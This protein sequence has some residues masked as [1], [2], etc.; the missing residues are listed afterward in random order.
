MSIGLTS[1]QKRLL[2]GL[3]AKHNETGT[4]KDLEESKS[5]RL[6][7]EST[8]ALASIRRRRQGGFGDRSCVEVRLGLRRER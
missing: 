6:T 4:R 3:M 5:A 7:G 1:A 2:G 8:G